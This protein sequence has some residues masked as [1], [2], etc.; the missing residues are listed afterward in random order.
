MHSKRRDN[1]GRRNNGMNNLSHHVGMADAQPQF[2]EVELWLFVFDGG[3]RPAV[4]HIIFNVT[5]QSHI[6]HCGQASNC[7]AF[8]VVHD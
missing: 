4:S 6:L 5:A 1:G 8:C 7:V 3:G 2:K